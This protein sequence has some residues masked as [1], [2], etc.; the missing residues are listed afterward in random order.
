LKKHEPW[1]DEGCSELLDKKK[2]GKSQILQ[3]LSEINGDNL[4]N[5]RHEASRH[6]RNRKR[7]YMKNKIN[8]VETN[9]KNKNI[10]DPCKGINY[11]KLGYHR[12]NN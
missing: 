11:Y 2:Q 4:N 9:S 12:R 5:V 3:D 10:R 6:F 1:L 7:E 8:E